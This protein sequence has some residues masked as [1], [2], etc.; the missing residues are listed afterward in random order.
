MNNGLSD[1]DKTIVMLAGLL[2]DIGHA[3]FSHSFES[4]LNKKHEDYTISIITE[5]SEVNDILNSYSSPFTV[6]VAV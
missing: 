2:H 6:T 1:Y 3:P 4:I 5:K